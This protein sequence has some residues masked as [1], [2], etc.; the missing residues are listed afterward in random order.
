MPLLTF[1]CK[2]QLSLHHLF[3]KLGGESLFEPV[4]ELGGIVLNLLK[5]LGNP[6]CRT[7]TDHLN[8]QKDNEDT[9]EYRRLFT[10]YGERD[11]AGT[12]VPQGER[13]FAHHMHGYTHHDDADKRDKAAHAE[14]KDT[15]TAGECITQRGFIAIQKRAYGDTHQPFTG[16]GATVAQQQGFYKNGGYPERGL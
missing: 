3:L 7:V 16:G 8:A 9:K 1:F 10:G 2:V 13:T 11:G 12:G 6:R 15:E 5:H 14:Y 4:G